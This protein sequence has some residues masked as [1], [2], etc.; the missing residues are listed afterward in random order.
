MSVLMS[1]HTVGVIVAALAVASL[2]TGCAGQSSAPVLE[3]DPEEVRV[4]S[5]S[6]PTDS[7]NEGAAV[8]YVPAFD[9]GVSIVVTE[10]W[11][12]TPAHSVCK[13]EIAGPVYVDAASQCVV[14]PV[15][16]DS[17]GHLQGVRVRVGGLSAGSS[18]A[19]DVDVKPL[20]Q[21]SRYDWDYLHGTRTVYRLNAEIPTAEEESK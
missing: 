10:V 6:A 1:R 21:A 4:E 18:V 14:E 20:L 19:L 9:D 17:D 5:V 2:L 15:E 7:T 8:I 11:R 13:I 3:H 12:Q 16:R